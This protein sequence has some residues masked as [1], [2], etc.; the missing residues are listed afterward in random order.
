[1]ACQRHNY[2][3][4]GFWLFQYNPTTHFNFQ[5]TGISGDLGSVWYCLAGSNHWV[6][7]YDTHKNIIMW[8]GLV[9]HSQRWYIHLSRSLF[10]HCCWWHLFF[11]WFLGSHFFSFN[12]YLFDHVITCKNIQN[13][14]YTSYHSQPAAN[15]QQWIQIMLTFAIE[16]TIKV[17]AANNYSGRATKILLHLHKI[18]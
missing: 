15:N 3:V 13:S 12:I 18:E 14:S 4:Y 8:Y 11:A 9:P 7:F 6:F 1:M 5:K 10:S 17:V 16:V 2:S